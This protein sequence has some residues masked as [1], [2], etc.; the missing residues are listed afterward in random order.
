MT[1]PA[2][3]QLSPVQ[4]GGHL[5][6]KPT[7]QLK[8]QI[9]QDISFFHDVDEHAISEARVN[10]PTFRELIWNLIFKKDLSD[11]QKA[12]TIFRWMTC[13]ELQ[14]ISFENVKPGSEEQ[15]LT[16]F[17]AGKTTYAR[18]FE[19]MARNAGLSCA[20]IT[21]WAK[22][23]DYRPGV[24][25]TQR[26]VNHSWNAVYIDGNWQLID[27]HWATRFL[28]SDNDL[29]PDNLVYE[30]DD[31]Y[32]LSE[33]SQ[34]AYTHRP[35]NS[36]WQLLDSPQ[37]EEQFEDYPLV[38]SYFFTN[39]M[40]FP[41]NWNHG[42]V[43]AKKG[44]VA[45]P[46]GFSKKTTFTY[47][48][49]Y[50]DGMMEVVNGVELNRY[51]IQDTSD[52]DVTYYIRLPCRGDF[53]LIVFAH[54]FIDPV[55]SPENVFKAVAE[56]KIVGGTDVPSKVVPFP[57]CSDLSWG[58]DAVLFQFG[59]KPHNKEAL[60]KAPKGHAEIVFDKDHP[61]VR[62]YARLV[63]DGVPDG[64]LKRAVTVKSEAD[65]V[66][67][68][69]ELPQKGE[70][71]LEVFAN[72]PH[73]DGD[74]FT[75]VSQYLC[76][77]SDGNFGDVYGDPSQRVPVNKPVA[78]HS[79][80]GESSSEIGNY[81]ETDVLTAVSIVPQHS[82]E[83]ELEYEPHPEDVYT[84]PI[85]IQPPENFVVEPAI[86]NN[87]DVKPQGVLATHK[88]FK[89]LSIFH[90]VDTHVLEVSKLEHLTFRDI[91]WHLIFARRMKNQL[92]IA[93]ALFL[94]LCTK[95][96]SKMNFPNVEKGSPEEVLMNLQKGLT[97]YARVYETL[98]SY[99]GLHCKTLTGYAK[100]ADYKP[101]MKF[102][103]HPSQ[104][105]WNAVLVNGVW[106]LV[107]CHWAARRLVGQKTQ[108]AP[109]DN[110]RYELDEY[111]F[112]PAPSQ[113]IYTHFPDDPNWQLL[114]RP[115]TLDEFE[116]L[117]P[118]KPAF[119]R[120]GLQLLSHTTAVIECP[121][122]VSDVSIRI[123]CPRKKSSS[124]RF[125]F[126]LVKDDGSDSFQGI[127]L[128][129]FA[130]QELVGNVCYLT[131]RPPQQGSYL[132][133]IYA[134]DLNE[135]VKEGVYG[136][137]CEYKIVCEER[138]V[139]PRPFPPCVHTTWGPGDSASKFDMVPQQTGSI[140]HALDGVAEIR[141]TL[142]TKLRF[143]HKLKS[144]EADEK[145]LAQNV[146]YRVSGDTAIFRVHT[147]FVG[148]YGL[149]IYA[150]NPETGGAALQHAYQYLIISKSLPE[151]GAPA[152]FPVLP[153]GSLGP[154]SAFAQCGLSTV[155]HVD[156]YIV[157]DTGDLQ[158]TFRLAQPLR[159]TSQLTLISESP[160]K[161]CS[162]YILQ[163]GSGGS[164]A[165]T[166]IIQPPHSGVFKFQLFGVPQSETTEN[167][168]S[169]YTY[170]INC[171]QVAPGQ[172]PFPKQ[173]GSWKDGCYLYEPLEGH[174]QANRASKG[175]ASSLQNVYF[176][177]DVPKAHNV[178][179]VVG[180]E[181]TQLEQKQPGTW[182][183]EVKM[184]KLWE[185]ERKATVCANNGVSTTSY[186]TLLEFS[187]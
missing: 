57:G 33:P 42:V 1:V 7:Q 29:N 168:P 54:L 114:E 120:H 91:I 3:F 77:Y 43:N 70:Y 19:A 117:V 11:L 12:R 58:P 22:G 37:T 9:Y 59:L 124:L 102:A 119:F 69:I 14:T 108:Q 46:V 186:S 53:Y 145:A 26:P 76:C 125:T 4:D 113:L 133:V 10:Y 64:D 92:D 174:L 137:V 60:L 163:Q 55:K 116:D 50:G 110:V 101:G 103:N 71:G 123:Q 178:A 30:Y 32:F 136:G 74:M 155:S 36:A 87:A 86:D 52:A 18:I 104:H 180:T 128:N 166:F 121:A 39:E 153:S 172:L 142:V 17:K 31:F 79:T 49:V 89:D 181:W 98:C 73:K 8:S 165:V 81:S 167:L 72:D 173:F 160:V 135:K 65:K 6:P 20:T 150:N 51:V 15:L 143:V 100:G 147:P 16:A 95:D 47:K 184:E 187:L 144:N 157:T 140:L 106:Q 109:L 112:M 90:H 175:S 28:Q 177:M 158:V 61:D 68:D 78:K 130:M 63:K 132:V 23:V 45:L 129:R 40:F 148:E 138:T 179:V 107:D 93:R 97:T 164:D 5:P 38:K 56:Y 99:A 141:F 96:L 34:L 111:Y 159:M 170:I 154:T 67:V 182:Q 48:L 139:E 41:P 27:S 151:S 122:N 13:K 162:E 183:G 149:E 156:P 25:I 169:V 2:N 161:D 35:E 44:I 94:W 185:T 82:V 88:L 84:A 171:R 126:S 127:K 146:L 85:D 66:S 134:K 75:H 152:P 131:V 80:I 21:G 24:A 115:L 118:V 83:P 62:V 176:K 105:S